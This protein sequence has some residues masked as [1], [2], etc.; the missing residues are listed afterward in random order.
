MRCTEKEDCECNECKMY[1]NEKSL[2]IGYDE[3]NS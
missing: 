1:A 3:Y 2:E